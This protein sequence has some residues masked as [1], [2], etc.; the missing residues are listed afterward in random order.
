MRLSSYR[1]THAPISLCYLSN[2]L[3]WG[4]RH[5]G[6]TSFPVLE[7]LGCVA[8]QSR[9]VPSDRFWTLL[10]GVETTDGFGRLTLSDAVRAGERLELGVRHDERF[11]VPVDAVVLPLFVFAS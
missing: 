1:L 5:K 8:R 4:R 2:G 3:C 6:L 7:C 9:R 10:R 11:G